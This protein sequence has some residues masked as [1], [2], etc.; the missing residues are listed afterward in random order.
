MQSLSDIFLLQD[1][2][3]V[4]RNNIESL[5]FVLKKVLFVMWRNIFKHNA[6]FFNKKRK[7]T[8]FL[9]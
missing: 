5:C 2:N 6:F 8:D 7:T 1:L 9:F 3:A 4:I